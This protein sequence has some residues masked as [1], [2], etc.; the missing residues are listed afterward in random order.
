MPFSRL[1]IHSGRK[2]V[3]QWLVISSSTQ[4][5]SSP[6]LSVVLFF[7]FFFCELP[8]FWVFAFFLYALN[9]LLHSGPHKCSLSFCICVTG[10]FQ[11]RVKLVAVQSEH[12]VWSNTGP[13]LNSA[14]GN[15]PRLHA[16]AFWWLL[17]ET[18]RLYVHVGMCLC[19]TTLK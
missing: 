17:Y 1:L 3:A 12:T 6:S 16:R 8:V 5:F 7:F 14:A 19:K 4:T 18:E 10:Y 11:G 9:Y 15:I 13:N 2:S